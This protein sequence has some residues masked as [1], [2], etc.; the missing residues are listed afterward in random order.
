MLP[1]AWRMR[2]KVIL[3]ACF[4]RAGGGFLSTPIPPPWNR[5]LSDKKNAQDGSQNFPDKESS[6]NGEAKQM[7]LKLSQGPQF[8]LAWPRVVLSCR[9]LQSPPRQCQ[10]T[11]KYT[12]RLDICP[13]GSLLSETAAIPLGKLLVPALRSG[14]LLLGEASRT[15]TIW[16]C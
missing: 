14:V 8:S 4:P 5:T 13:R 12:S 7:I 16:W 2:G 3:C 15:A 9:S 10:R 1:P 6:V 11:Q